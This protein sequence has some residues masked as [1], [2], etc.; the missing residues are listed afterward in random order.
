MDVYVATAE[1]HLPVEGELVTV[2]ETVSKYATSVKT[3]VGALPYVNLALYQWV[4]LTDSLHYLAFIGT[5][6]DPVPSGS[7]IGSRTAIP[8]GA[9]VVT[10]VYAFGFVPASVVA[11]VWKN[12]L[13]P[14]SNIFATVR[15]GSV[16]ANGF[17][18]DL[19]GPTPG[20]GY[21]LSWVVTA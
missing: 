19:S 21:F 8:A 17:M 12:V 6:P 11:I 14:G 3:L 18:V 9:D 1:F 2:G 7:A 4:G 5:I 16:T 13:L 15:A 10:T 20:A